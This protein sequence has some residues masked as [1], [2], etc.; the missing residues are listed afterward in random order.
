MF[1]LL[2]SNLLYSNL[3]VKPYV[4]SA[5][6]RLGNPL[7]GWKLTLCNRTETLMNINGQ[8]RQR[9]NGKHKSWESNSKFIS[10]NAWSCASINAS[11]L[12]W[13]FFR[14]CQTKYFKTL[15]TTLNVGINFKSG[16]FTSSSV[17]QGLAC[18]ICLGKLLP[19]KIGIE[20]L[21]ITTNKKACLL[22]FFLSQQYGLR[23]YV[24]RRSGTI[25]L[26]L[27]T[28]DMGIQMSGGDMHGWSN[29]QV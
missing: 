4:D 12:W 22:F 11:T 18:R 25:S 6:N 2:R 27:S 28:W 14:D 7:M 24:L 20:Q 26:I 15:I 13:W 17:S 23:I 3:A 8:S 1:L 10:N 5:G 9:W 21:F 19:M 16:I 29:L